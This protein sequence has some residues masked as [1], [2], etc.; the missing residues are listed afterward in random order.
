M[1]IKNF[2]NFTAIILITARKAITA[3]FGTLT[4]QLIEVFQCS[5]TYSMKK[6]SSL[7]YCCN[8]FIDFIV[9]DP[10]LESKIN[11]S[12]FIHNMFE[13]NISRLH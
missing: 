6:A 1:T 10:A 3:V 13:L 9:C 11:C 4:L 7:F 5:V 12:L 2:A 8:A